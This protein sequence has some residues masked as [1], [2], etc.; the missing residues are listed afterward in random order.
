MALLKLTHSV[1]SLQ[2]FSGA[3]LGA[4]TWALL[5]GKSAKM[6]VRAGMQM[7]QVLT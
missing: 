2:A 7:N 3:T 1:G 4:I 5:V 6:A